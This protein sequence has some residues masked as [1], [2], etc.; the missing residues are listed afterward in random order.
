MLR[1]WLLN[2]NLVSQI[3][4]FNDFELNK[5]LVGKT[6]LIGTVTPPNGFTTYDILAYNIYYISSGDV[7]YGGFYIPAG[8]LDIYFTY[9]KHGFD[10]K[11]ISLKITWKK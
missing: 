6:T 8:R 9:L 2:S 7:N 5:D 1:N 11:G 3:Y 10:T 4:R